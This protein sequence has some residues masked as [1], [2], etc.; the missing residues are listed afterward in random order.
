MAS[1]QDRHPPEYDQAILISQ[2]CDI[3]SEA[4]DRVEV[5]FGSI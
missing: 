4:E 2:D 5:M 3:I 1:F